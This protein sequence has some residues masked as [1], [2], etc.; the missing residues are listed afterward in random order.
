MLKSA[1]LTI[2]LEPDFR[3]Y[4]TQSEHPNSPSVHLPSFYEE[5]VL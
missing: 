2:R 1:T 5:C 4:L 3:F